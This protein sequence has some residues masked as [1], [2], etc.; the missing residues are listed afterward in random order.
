MVELAFPLQLNEDVD[1]LLHIRPFG[2]PG[3]LEHVD[4]L[5]PAE[6]GDTSVYAPSYVLLPVRVS[7]DVITEGVE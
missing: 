1:H 2:N 3:G 7:Q 5:G 4:L 6:R